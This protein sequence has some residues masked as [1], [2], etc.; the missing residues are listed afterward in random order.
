MRIDIKDTTIII[1]VRIDSI[2]R[3]ENLILVINHLKSN[4]DT[5]IK[6]IEACGYNSGLIS[7]LI[8]EDVFYSFVE[9]KDPI[10]HRTKYIN[11]AASEVATNIIG[12]WDADVIIEPKQIVESV[13]KLRYNEYDVAM[14]YDGTFLDT[15]LVIRSYYCKD[16]NIE[17]LK[18]NQSKMKSMYSQPDNPCSVGGAFLILTEK[19]RASGF[20]NEDFYG[21]GPEDI[22]RYN[23]W[24]R[25]NYRIFRNSGCLFHLSHPR[26]ENSG[27]NVSLASFNKKREILSLMSDYTEKEFEK[28]VEKMKILDYS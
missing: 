21:W 4:F 17:Y 22:E 16:K 18:R 25:L 10:F 11:M 1:P 28:Y 12:V 26:T 13:E 15:S 24:L 27:V 8:G 20:E 5:N 9:D 14:P 19:Y 7:S 6:V 23:R 3:L 2:V